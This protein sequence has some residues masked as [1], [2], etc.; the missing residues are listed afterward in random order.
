[1]ETTVKWLGNDGMAFSAETGSGH[2]VNMDGAP[3]AARPE[4]GA[5][6]PIFIGAAT[7]ACNEKQHKMH[8]NNCIYRCIVK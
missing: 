8:E 2:L 7:C 5:D 1:M 6:I 3:D 4:N